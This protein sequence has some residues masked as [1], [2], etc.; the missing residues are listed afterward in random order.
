MVKLS[1]MLKPSSGN[2]GTIAR[3]LKKKCMRKQCAIKYTFYECTDLFRVSVIGWSVTFT[4]QIN[5]FANQFN[6]FV[7]P[8]NDFAKP[9]NDLAKQNNDFARQNNDLANQ[10]V[11]IKEDRINSD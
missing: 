11:S 1:K 4:N 8:N 2:K 3:R 10:N 7:K 5:D 9:N 6:D